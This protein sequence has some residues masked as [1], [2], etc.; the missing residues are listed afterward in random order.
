MDLAGCA[1]NPWVPFVS[2][3]ALPES[4]VQAF[5]AMRV[6]EVN[7]GEPTKEDYIAEFSS[8]TRLTQVTAWILRFRAF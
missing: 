8:L 5:A 4:P 3:T 1:I 2:A 7:P 6:E